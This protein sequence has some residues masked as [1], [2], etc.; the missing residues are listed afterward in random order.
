MGE[1]RTE[2][3]K[4]ATEDE[5]KRDLSEDFQIRFSELFFE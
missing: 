3:E 2:N 5:G 4:R 1:G